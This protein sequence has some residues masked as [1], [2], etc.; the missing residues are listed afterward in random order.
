ME[1]SC[2]TIWFTG[3]A[4]VSPLFSSTPGMVRSSS[5]LLGERGHHLFDLG[6]EVGDGLV[7]VVDVGEDLPTTTA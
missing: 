7:Q 4:S 2:T 1:R 6:G 5:T 3:G